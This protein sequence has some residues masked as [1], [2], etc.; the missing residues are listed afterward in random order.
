MSLKKVNS[1]QPK[2]FDFDIDKEL[3]AKWK[4]IRHET[5]G[6]AIEQL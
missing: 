4:L 6:Y 5:G 1:E 3:N 2:T